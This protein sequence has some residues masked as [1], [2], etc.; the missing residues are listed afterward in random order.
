[1]IYDIYTVHLIHDVYIRY[2]KHDTC[3]VYDIMYGTYDIYHMTDKECSGGG[4][5]R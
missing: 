5:P 4:T 1:M 3:T 2:V